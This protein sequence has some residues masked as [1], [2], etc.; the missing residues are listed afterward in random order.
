MRRGRGLRPCVAVVL[1]AMAGACIRGEE[2]PERSVAGGDPKRGEHLLRTF[3]CDGCHTIPGVPGAD[4]TVGPP[5]TDWAER[6]Y[7]AGALRNTPENLIRWIVDPQVVEPT[8]MPD[9]GVD[10]EAARHM[11]AYLYTL[12]DANPLGAPHPLSARILERLSAEHGPAK[13]QPDR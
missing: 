1:A 5:L 9:L 7:I 11:A 8:A 6:Q 2:G 12:G 4:A 13:S 10:E 3:G